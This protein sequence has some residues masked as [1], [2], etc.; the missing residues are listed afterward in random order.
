VTTSTSSTISGSYAGVTAPA[1]L[2]VSSAAVLSSLTLNPT[3]VGGGNTSQGTVTLSAAAPSPGVVV[4]LSSSNTAA[5]TVPASVTIASGASSAT[6]TVNTSSVG[7]STSSTIS[8]SYAGVTDTAVLSVQ[9][10]PTLIPQ[11]GWSLLSVDSQQTS[12]GD[13]YPAVNSFDGNPSTFW[14]TEWCPTVAGLP[15]EIEINLGAIYNING[16]TYLP[17][18]DGC[19]NGWISQYQ[20]YVSTDGVN[21]GNPVASGTFNYGTA[22]LGCPGAS[23]VPAIQVLFPSTS[24]QYIQLRALSEVNGNPYTTAAEI[25]VLQ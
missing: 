23:V 20:F 13:S 11:T 4:T 2:T 15:H 1:K 25:N 10:T 5:A 14:H 3:S 12:C 22:V 18:Q 7:T 24:G 19:S 21:W 17:R 8:A 6:F 9:S 16:F